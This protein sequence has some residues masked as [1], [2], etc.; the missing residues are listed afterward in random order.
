MGLLDQINEVLNVTP[1]RYWGEKANRLGSLLSDSAST[2][3]QAYA[4]ANGPPAPEHAMTLGGL[5]ADFTPVVG[6]VKSAYDGIQSARQGD[7]LGAALGGLGALPVIPNIATM[8]HGVP[9]HL[10]KFNEAN[11][12]PLT[13]IQKIQPASKEKTVFNHDQAKLDAN[14]SLQDAWVRVMNEPLPLPGD[15]YLA[16]AIYEQRKALPPRAQYVVDRD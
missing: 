9:W 5:L 4:S 15:P 12:K 11:T 7:Y 10:F 6:D 16:A 14:Q 2:G 1:R 13:G 3:A 8:G